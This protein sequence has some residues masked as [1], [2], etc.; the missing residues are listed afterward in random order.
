MSVKLTLVN[1]YEYFIKSLYKDGY[2]Y[3]QLKVTEPH[4]R[5]LVNFL[6]EVH[7]DLGLHAVDDNYLFNYIAFTFEYILI[8]RPNL[9]S[10][11]IPFNQ[12]FSP[13]AYKRWQERSKGR[14]YYVSRALQ[15][16]G[17]SR[18]DVIPANIPLI[19]IEELSESEE[20]I[21]RRVVNTAGA[22]A[23]CL[24]STTLFNHKSKYC[25]ICVKKDVCKKLLSQI[26]AGA[27]FDRGY[28]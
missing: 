16:K 15:E 5:S 19:S 21:K 22:L 6:V 28:L 9:Q 10:R 17:I 11:R 24:E 7:K 27:A 18:L 12:I 23:I 20:A 13:S 3:F 25:Q 8:K 14:Q 26:N 2:E 4:K 1:F